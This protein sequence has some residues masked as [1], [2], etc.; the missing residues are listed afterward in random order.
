MSNTHLTV[1]KLPII[2]GEVFVVLNRTSVRMVISVGN[3]PMWMTIIVSDNICTQERQYAF[4]CTH[5]QR[6]KRNQQTWVQDPSYYRIHTLRKG[7]VAALLHGCYDI[8]KWLHIARRKG[9]G[10]RLIAPCFTIA[11]PKIYVY[12]A[13]L[14]FRDRIVTSFVC[15]IPQTSAMH[16]LPIP[17]STPEYALHYWVQ[18]RFFLMKWGSYIFKAGNMILTNRV[19]TL[20]SINLQWK[21]RHKRLL[22]PYRC[23]VLLCLMLEIETCNE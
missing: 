21:C 5:L 15:H 9:W 12:F 23:Q 17:I 13:Y 1:S 18:P 3:L 6:E 11:N 22:R 10:S 8:Y 4:G 7:I 14:P 2:T 20:T 16:W 19:R